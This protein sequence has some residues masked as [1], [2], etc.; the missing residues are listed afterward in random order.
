MVPGQVYFDEDLEELDPV[1][2]PLMLDLGIPYIPE[3]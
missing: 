1:E 3:S 2:N